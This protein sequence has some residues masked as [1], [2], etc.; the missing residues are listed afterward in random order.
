MIRQARQC[1][2]FSDIDRM[3]DANKKLVD[4]NK[5]LEIDNKLIIDYFT[6]VLNPDEIEVAE[7]VIEY[8]HKKYENKV[9]NRVVIRE[10]KKHDIKKS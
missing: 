5:Q 6:G 2:G 3:I 1:M 9:D 4:T 10:R 8:Y 7:R